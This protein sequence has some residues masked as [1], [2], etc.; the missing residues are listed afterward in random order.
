[1]DRATAINR[2][3]D[4]LQ[5]M[6]TVLR[7][8]ENLTAYL[9]RLDFA[10][11]D[12]GTH[13]NKLQITHDRGCVTENIYETTEQQ[14]LESKKW[15]EARIHKERN[16]DDDYLNNDTDDQDEMTNTQKM[17]QFR[18]LMNAKVESID[19]FMEKILADFEVA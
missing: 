19:R 13:H 17:A 8:R 15:T 10:W 16:C 3:A 2:L 5:K 14:Y 4:N 18:R 7:S 6:G 9:E 12:F 11:Q 1:M